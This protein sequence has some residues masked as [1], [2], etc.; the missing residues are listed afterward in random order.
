M[1]NDSET[2][3]HIQCLAIFDEIEGD[4]KEL[5][6]VKL[7]G[8]AFFDDLKTLFDCSSVDWIGLGHGLWLYAAGSSLA[9]GK[10]FNVPAMILAD[11]YGHGRVIYGP[12]LI[13]AAAHDEHVSLTRTNREEILSTM[14][15][16]AGLNWAGIYNR[17]VEILSTHR[18]LDGQLD[19]L[20][21]WMAPRC[22][23]PNFSGKNYR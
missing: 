9:K 8:H 23:I 5:I 1:T 10:T 21:A 3:G 22:G 15:V 4:R 13:A 11:S 19:V 16:M 2:S 12:V 17:I 18:D 14:K 6:D 20:D 7:R